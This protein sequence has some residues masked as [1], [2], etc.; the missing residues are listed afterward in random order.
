MKSLMKTLTGLLLVLTT[1]SAWGSPVLD[2]ISEDDMK[3]VTRAMGANFTH[4]SMLGASKMG[5]VFGF[6]VGLVGAQTNTSKLNEIA[7]RQGGKIS[8]LYNAGLMG[9]VGIPFGIAFE[10]VLIP[11]LE[12]NDAKL[13]SQSFA[14]KWNINDVIPI[15]PVNLALRGFASNASFKFS[16]TVASAVQT[17]E[18]QTNVSG[19][20]LLFSPQIPLVEP[21]VGVGLLSAKNKLSVTGSTSIFDAVYTTGTSNSET[22]SGTQV[23]AGVDVNLVLL[24]IGVEYSQAFDNQRYGLKLGFGF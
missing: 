12:S 19:V 1:C 18:N 9:A 10:A 3:E 8:S 21:Y 15:L 22:V 5:T 7:E 6:Q 20:Q 14:V 24:K 16:Q 17:V 2:S 23:L 13:A 4:N 11:T